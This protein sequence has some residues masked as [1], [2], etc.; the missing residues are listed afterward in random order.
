MD[1][2]TGLDETNRTLLRRLRY[3][4]IVTEPQRISLLLTQALLATLDNLEIGKHRIG[5]C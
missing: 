5:L 3:I 4:L 2:G 1:M